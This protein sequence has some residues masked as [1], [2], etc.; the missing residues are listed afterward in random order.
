MVV[1]ASK[2]VPLKTLRGKVG[3]PPDFDKRLQ[4]L[5]EAK[6]LVRERDRVRAAFPILLGEDRDKY[7]RAASRIAERI[8]QEFRPELS[9]ILEEVD[10]RGW[11]EWQFHFL[12]SQLFDSQLMWVNLINEG[13]VPPIAPVRYWVVYPPNAAT[14][15][16]SYF[17][18]QEIGEFFF[19]VTWTPKGADTTDPIRQ[20]SIALLAAALRGGKLPGRL[21][22]TGLVDENGDLR[23][24]VLRPGDQLLEHLRQASDKYAKVVTAAIPVREFQRLTGADHQLAGAM[25]YH[26]V[27]YELLSRLQSE[28]KITLPPALQAR[29]HNSDLRG[30]TAIIPVYQPFIGMIEAA[31]KP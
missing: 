5:V 8:K 24:P 21:S 13:F 15:G 7:M 22:G 20:N 30:T 9:G 10:R 23:I 6:L 16:T 29:V 18:Q 1:C 27:T 14:A 25:A 3:S 11:H 4:Q 31:M 17:P 2:N 26:D 28:G 12:W 19:A